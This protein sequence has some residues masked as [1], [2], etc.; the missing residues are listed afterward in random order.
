M[1][2]HAVAQ[3]L[4]EI[5]D[6]T[7]TNDIGERPNSRMANSDLEK[8]QDSEYEKQLLAKVYDLLRCGDLK[9]AQEMLL[10]SQNQ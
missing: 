8:I 6:S 3:W 2:V 10:R 9:K 1:T 7:N 5:Y 4:E